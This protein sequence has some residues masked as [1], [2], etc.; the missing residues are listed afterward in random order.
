[1]GTAS[2]FFSL[3]EYEPGRERKKFK[4]KA[5][6]KEPAASSLPSSSPSLTSTLRHCPKLGGKKEGRQQDSHKGPEERRDCKLS[7]SY[8]SHRH[9][10]HWVM[11][12]Q[13]VRRGQGTD[14]WEVPEVT[15]GLPWSQVLSWRRST[16]FFGPRLVQGH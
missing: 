12:R 16:S 13:E 6:K 8:S 4:R 15:S 5:N 14:R 10:C 11:G 3:L 1:M 9:V 7:P 2:L